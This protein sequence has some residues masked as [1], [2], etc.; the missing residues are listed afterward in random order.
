MN[1]GNR[2]RKYACCMYTVAKKIAARPAHSH[3]SAGTP[4][5]ERHDDQRQ[6]KQPVEACGAVGALD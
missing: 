2:Y 5:G 4:P 1:A 3:C 6:Q